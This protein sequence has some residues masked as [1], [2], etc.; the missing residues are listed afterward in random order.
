MALFADANDDEMAMHELTLKNT[1]Q[2]V[3]SAIDSLTPTPSPQTT[4]N[5]NNNKKNAKKQN[6]ATEQKKVVFDPIY[7]IVSNTVRP[8]YK[9][10]QTCY[11]DNKI[12]CNHCP[13]L[14]E[15]NTELYDPA[16]AAEFEKHHRI[17]VDVVLKYAVNLNQMKFTRITC[18]EWF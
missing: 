4:N 17:P 14:D 16:F 5:N 18:K 6:T 9:A 11:F 13:L 3:Q 7:K 1:L 10:C 8:V 15:F 12:T 2:N